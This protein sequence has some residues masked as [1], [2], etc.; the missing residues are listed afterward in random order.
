MKFIAAIILTIAL[1]T[2]AQAIEGVAWGTSRASARQTCFANQRGLRTAT[3]YSFR[4]GSF[5]GTRRPSYLGAR[6]NARVR[7]MRGVRGHLFE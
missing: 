1:A 2:Q 4:S 6:I 3:V 5:Y 7:A